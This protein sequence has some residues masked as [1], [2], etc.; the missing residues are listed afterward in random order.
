VGKAGRGQGTAFENYPRDAHPGRLPGCGL[1]NLQREPAIV[2]CELAVG[3]MRYQRNLRRKNKELTRRGSYFKVPVLGSYLS[4]LG[5]VILIGDAAHAMPPTGGQGAAMAFE[6]AMTLAYILGRSS[7]VEFPKSLLLKW[8][9]HR[10][11]RIAKI[12]DFTTKG[13]DIRKP[14]RSSWERI[15]KEWLMWI[16]LS[17]LGPQGIKWIYDYRAEDVVGAVMS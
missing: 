13:G 15:L 3:A 6:D 2:S 9:A 12:L 11:E 16:Y 7:L 5:R 8:E 4:R 17:W 10:M 14:V 1:C